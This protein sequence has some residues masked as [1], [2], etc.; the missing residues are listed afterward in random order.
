[1]GRGQLCSGVKSIVKRAVD[2]FLDF[3]ATELIACPGQ[4]IE[5]KARRVSVPLNEVNPEDLD[6]FIPIRQIDE[7]DLL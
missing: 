1:M 3:R 6:A 2:R 5:I 7:E 4:G